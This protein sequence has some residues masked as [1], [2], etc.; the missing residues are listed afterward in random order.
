VDCHSY[1]AAAVV[2]RKTQII[3]YVL[4]FVLS[5]VLW[6]TGNLVWHRHP[7]GRVLVGVV[8]G[9]WIVAVVGIAVI[10]FVRSMKNRTERET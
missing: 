9:G 8:L 6:F 4:C 1:G 3:P 7:E 2:S 10:I 5:F